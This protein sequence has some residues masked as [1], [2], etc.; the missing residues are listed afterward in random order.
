MSKL[1][2]SVQ[3]RIEKEAEKFAFV[4]DSVPPDEV[5]RRCLTSEAL[6][7]ERL[8]EALEAIGNMP[9]STDPIA[10]IKHAR[11]AVATYYLEV[12]E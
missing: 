6:R 1:P 4:G 12:G 10:L 8:A 7:A 5:A 3:Q 2:E 9:K 11:Q